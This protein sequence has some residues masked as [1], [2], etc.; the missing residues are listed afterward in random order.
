MIDADAYVRQITHPRHRKYA[1][2]TLR[3]FR[4]PNATAKL[5]PHDATLV[6]EVADAIGWDL[7]I[8]VTE[9]TRMKPTY[10]QRLMAGAENE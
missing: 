2:A 5:M 3:Y 8:L 7:T 4:D 9:D 6:G 1:E 10:Y